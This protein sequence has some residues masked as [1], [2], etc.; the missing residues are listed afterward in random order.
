MYLL[1]LLATGLIFFSGCAK[2]NSIASQPIPVASKEATLWFDKITGDDD[3]KAKVIASWID[4]TSEQGYFQEVLNVSL[5]NERRIALA[6]YRSA[7]EAYHQGDAKSAKILGKRAEEMIKDRVDWTGRIEHERVPYVYWSQGDRKAE[8]L[9]KKLPPGDVLSKA[10]A[11]LLAE[12][13]WKGEQSSLDA[14]IGYPRAIN[15][16]LHRSDQAGDS[17]QRQE[18]QAWISRAIS[19]AN[20]G[21]PGDRPFSLCKIVS[22]GTRWDEKAT[23]RPLIDSVIEDVK[24]TPYQIED[25]IVLLAEAAQGLQGLGE[26][27]EAKSVLILAEQDAKRVPLVFRPVASA[28]IANAWILLGNTDRA[29]DIWLQASKDARSHIHP[30]ARMMNAI[31]ILM[32]YGKS[33]KVPSPAVRDVLDSISR[34]EGGDMVLDP[35]WT[36]SGAETKTNKPGKTE[37]KK[38]NTAQTKR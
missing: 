24:A 6:L 23:L 31:G 34:G 20:A 30:R 33:N 12:K 3:A 11:A 25:R 21:Y 19:S 26:I 2:K 35:G 5:P 38:K 16:M 7:V 22:R 9:L 13:I 28:A 8:G 27:E 36:V 4:Q 15:A 29:E 18:A 1:I 17:G 14:A 10:E 32:S 37:A